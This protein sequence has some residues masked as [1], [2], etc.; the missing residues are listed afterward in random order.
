MTPLEFLEFRD[1]LYPASGFQSFQWRLIETKL[2]LKIDQRVRFDESPFYKFLKPAQADTMK[3][4]LSQTSLFDGIQSWLERTPYCKDELFD[5]WSVYVS[6]M[7]KSLL[8]DKEILVNHPGLGP[9]QKAKSLQQL[10][11]ALKQVDSFRKESDY[12]KLQEAGHF[13]LSFKAFRSALFIQLYREVP[14][15]QIPHRL[16]QCLMDLE[17]KLTEWRQRHAQMALR[18]LGRKIGTGGSSGHDY[19][20]QTSDQHRIFGDFFALST[21]YLPRKLRPHLPDQ[22][23]TLLGSE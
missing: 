2:G 18:M 23:K 8:A 7:E 4:V 5:F 16:I 15:L 3:S 19:L 22:V 11:M 10:E 9:E 21:F 13:R 17:E 12:K 6:S 14:I 1:F 20:K